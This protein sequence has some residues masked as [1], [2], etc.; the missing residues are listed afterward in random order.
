MVQLNFPLFFK[1]GRATEI[2][3]NTL[4]Q[5]TDSFNFLL[6]RTCKKLKKKYNCHD[7]RISTAPAVFS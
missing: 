4:T 3:K 7:A 5:V 1:K 6:L 2:E